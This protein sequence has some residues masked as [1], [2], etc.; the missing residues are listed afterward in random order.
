MATQQQIAAI[1]DIILDEFD[2]D[3]ELFRASLAQIRTNTERITIQNQI[4]ALR[5]QQREA[6]D[7]IETQIQVLLGLK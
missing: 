1:A 5:K 2:A 7:A 6:N 4:D 3:P